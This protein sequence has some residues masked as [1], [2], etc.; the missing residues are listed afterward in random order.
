MGQ[1]EIGVY[2]QKTKKNCYLSLKNRCKM[3]ELK[4]DQNGLCV[5]T[6]YNPLERH[7]GIN[8]QEMH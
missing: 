7:I 2:I 5:R 8:P 1:R 3:N 4:V 6:K